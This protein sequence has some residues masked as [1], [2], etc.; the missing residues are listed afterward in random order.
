MTENEQ[1]RSLW[2]AA[3]DLAASRP[4]REITLSEIATA[5]GL[6]LS[7]IAATVSSKADV[8]R[9]FQRHNDRK[10]LA[11]LETEKLEGEPHDRLFDAMLR[12]IELLTPHKAAIR[13]MAGNPADGPV[14]WLSLIC[15]ALDT[16]NW[17]MNAAQ[18]DVSG[19]RGDLHAIGL[20][21]IYRDVLLIWLDDDDPGLAR[22]MASLDRKLR[23]AS[24]M[25]RRLETPLAI[26][27]GLYRA[28]S[29]FRQTRKQDTATSDAT[30]D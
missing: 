8:I 26:L 30:A 7:G 19:F 13:G 21:R 10:F 5:A 4:W 15:S 20:A 9:L 11:S 28:A 1:A 23:D 16:Q 29:T 22:T 27:A 17:I 2:T 24:A 18:L 3:L 25:A 12:R 6:T 14:E